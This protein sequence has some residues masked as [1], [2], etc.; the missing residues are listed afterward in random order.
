M[1]IHLETSR[2]WLRPFD[3]A[4][5]ESLHQL[6]VEPAVR[7]YLWD[8]QIISPDTVVEVIEASKKSFAEYGVGFWTLTG[9]EGIETFGFCGQRH[10]QE[11]GASNREVEVLYGLSTK[12]WGKGFSTEAAQQVIRCGFEQVSLDAIYAGVDAP[13][14]ASFRVMERL[15]M[16]FLRRTTVSGVTA[17][18]YILHRNQFQS[19][20][21][22]F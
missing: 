22:M 8:D 21:A 15:G 7:K 11:D 3:M 18:Y 6:W 17:I 5:A 9:K 19:G 1:D 14:E 13:N 4:D 2:L 20:I 12:H 10:F 16:K